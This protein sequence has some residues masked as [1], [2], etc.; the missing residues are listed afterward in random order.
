MP[1][2]DNTNFFPAL[3]LRRRLRL[4]F[5]HGDKY[6]PFLATRTSLTSHLSSV[7]TSITLESVLLLASLGLVIRQ[8][9]QYNTPLS[10]YG[11]YDTDGMVFLDG[12]G[13]GW[14]GA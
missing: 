6:P 3:S 12:G 14:D 7:G 11:Y 9:L 8:H 2:L 10:Q 1:R 4:L 13:V 5:A